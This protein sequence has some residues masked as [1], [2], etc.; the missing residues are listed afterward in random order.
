MAEYT[1]KNIIIDPT[2]EGIESLIGKEV[3]FHNIPSFCLDDANKELTGM[4]GVLVEIHK[5]DPSPFVIKKDDFIYS[6][7]CII[8]KKE[9]SKPKYMPFENEQEFFNSYQS[10]ESRL[11]GEKYFLSSHGIWL[12]RKECDI[13]LMVTE[14]WCYGVCVSGDIKTTEEL[15]GEYLSFNDSTTWENLLR[16]YT[17]LDGSPCGRLV[18]EEYK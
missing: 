4:S 1:F 5:D 7:N 11:T 13:P 16:L 8:E 2:K 15:E 18:E 14:I 9:E 3:Y 17:F 6:Y 10:A 12:K